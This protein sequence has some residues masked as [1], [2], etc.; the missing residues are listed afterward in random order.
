VAPEDAQA[1]RTGDAQ[2]DGRLT[3]DELAFGIGARIG[4]RNS[5][6]SVAVLA[7]QRFEDLDRAVSRPDEPQVLIVAAGNPGEQTD[8][9][10]REL[11]G[12]E[13]LS[14]PRQSGEP[15]RH[16]GRALERPR[17]DSETLARVVGETHEPETAVAPAAQ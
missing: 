9:C 13:S 5:T 12:V 10:P 11:S 2:H 3:V 14:D 8:L 4:E 16:P 7:D 1:T 17:R 6:A 15:R